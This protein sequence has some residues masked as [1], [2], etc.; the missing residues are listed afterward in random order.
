MEM[1]GDDVHCL[2]MDGLFPSPLGTG[3]LSWRTQGC[4]LGPPRMEESMCARSGLEGR[5]REH[6][7]DSDSS[8]AHPVPPHPLMARPPLLSVLFPCLHLSS[9]LTSLIIAPIFP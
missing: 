6:P 4:V 2:R 1:D 5:L 3:A 7:Q 8:S 9:C